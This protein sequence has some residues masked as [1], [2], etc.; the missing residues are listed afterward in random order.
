MNFV[1]QSSYRMT[2]NCRDFE[3]QNFKLEVGPI[4]FIKIKSE[5]FARV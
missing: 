4:V 1:D 5:H 2:L 3:Q